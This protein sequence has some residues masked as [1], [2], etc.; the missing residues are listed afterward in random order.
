MGRITKILTE[1]YGLFVVH[2][3][4]RRSVS[5]NIKRNGDTHFRASVEVAN[6]LFDQDCINWDS[7][8]SNCR[9]G[10]KLWSTYSSLPLSTA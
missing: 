3:G 5:I 4:I 7:R 1:L 9:N 8:F 6:W 10:G 2:D